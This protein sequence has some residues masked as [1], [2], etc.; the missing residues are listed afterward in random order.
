MKFVKICKFNHFW[1]ISIRQ[2]QEE[3]QES[4]RVNEGHFEVREN[5][6]K[7]DFTLL[8]ETKKSENNDLFIKK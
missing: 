2:F 1:R 5:F 7:R 8:A 4:L 3:Q 6:S